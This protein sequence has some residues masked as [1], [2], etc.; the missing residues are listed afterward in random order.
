MI[1][2]L[3]AYLLF[4]GGAKWEWWAIY[5]VLILLKIW[6]VRQAAIRAAEENFVIHKIIEESKKHDN[7]H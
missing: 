7:I 2:L 3:V 5:A 1:E 6:N 4:E